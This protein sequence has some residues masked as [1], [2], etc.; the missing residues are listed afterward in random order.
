MLSGHFLSVS[1]GRSTG[2]SIEMAGLLNSDLSNSRKLNR[3]KQCLL[4]TMFYFRYSASDNHAR[5]PQRRQTQIRALGHFIHLPDNFIQVRSGQ[6]IA[7]GIKI[8]S[9]ALKT[10]TMI[11]LQHPRSVVLFV[12]RAKEYIVGNSPNSL[13]QPM[14]LRYVSCTIFSQRGKNDAYSLLYSTVHE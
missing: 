4:L 5:Q 10:F 2:I 1:E 9:N 7:L 6:S 11:I 3:K 13:F 8:V 12:S 14:K